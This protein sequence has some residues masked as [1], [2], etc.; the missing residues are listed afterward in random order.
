MEVARFNATGNLT[1]VLLVNAAIGDGFAN[2]V[3]RAWLTGRL[4][5]MLFG[6]HKVQ[7]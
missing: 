5:S 4:S 2:G 6:E 3:N 7:R 1:Q